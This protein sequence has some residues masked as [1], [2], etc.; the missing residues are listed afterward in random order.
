MMYR[1][2]MFAVKIA[3]GKTADLIKSSTCM[4]VAS[5]WERKALAAQNPEL[6][7]C[8]STASPSEHRRNQSL[9]I[10]GTEVP[11]HR[12]NSTT[13]S[14]KAINVKAGLLFFFFFA[15]EHMLQANSNHQSQ[16]NEM[17]FLWQVL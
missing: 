6:L 5:Q 1:Q 12:T 11:S 7:F 15:W 4:D 3:I 16:W 13:M 17:V 2:R 9:G 10:S 14:Q 8:L